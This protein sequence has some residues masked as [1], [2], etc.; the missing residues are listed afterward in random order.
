[1]NAPLRALGLP[2]GPGG[3]SE[4]PTRERAP[5]VLREL[6]LLLGHRV[7]E[8]EL[9][10]ALPHAM[11][12]DTGPAVLAAAARLGL[13]HR[14]WAGTSRRLPASLLPA[15]WI[16]PGGRPALVIGRSEGFLLVAREDGAEPERVH[17][18]AMPGDLYVFAGRDEALEGADRPL[19]PRLLSEHAG[20]IAGL[21]ALS[22][23]SNLTSIALGLVVMI[24]FDMVIPGGQAAP[25]L[26]LGA[27]F[28][29]ALACD[30][31]L[32]TMLARGLG[33]IGERAERQVLGLVFAK[34]LRLPLS[35]VT[36]QDPAAQVMRMRD[37][38]TSREVFTGPL[39]Q[40]ILQVPL[41]IVFLGVIWALAG[42]VVVVPLLILPVQFAAALVL[43]PRAREK[44]HRAALLATER[45]HMILETLSHAG[46]LR[47]IGAEA[48]WLAR[49]R[50]ISAAAAAA[51][52][53]AARAGHAVELVAQLGLP[54]AACGVAAL[55]AHL[56]IEG[57][58]S[59]GALVAAIMLSWRV[60][61]PLQTLFLAISRA[62][63]IV[64]SVAQLHRLQALAEEARPAP[65]APR[66]KGHGRTLRLDGVVLRVPGG[67]T[68]LAGAS[69]ALPE[70][71]R[72]ALT[73][74]SGAGKSTLLRCALGLMPPQAGVVTLGGVNIAQL[75]PSTLRARM[76]YLPQRPA[77]I[78]GTVAQNLRLAAP[79]AEDSDLAEACE[80]VGILEHILAMPQGFA[81]RIN[82]LDKARLAQSLLQGLALAQALL[83][84]P[85]ILLLDDPTHA[86]DRAREERLAALL[87]RL[88]GTVGVL[89]VTHRADLIR[90]CDR[91]FTLDHGQLRVL[92][93]PAGAAL[94]PETAS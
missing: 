57:R 35:A 43:V 84:R 53:R 5:W 56:V 83:R 42:L 32:R 20:P 54:A 26:A 89:I 18:V 3:L 10:E 19:L 7:G 52:A 44:E 87:R 79:A 40:L 94:R 63:Q 24:A 30:V 33:R 11:A 23:L 81:T 25:L 4:G 66:A 28:L 29:G 73:G 50:D 36:S 80:E 65:D 16:A 13:A 67:G 72:V 6:A 76:G 86:L 49:F 47:A 64:D 58:V 62:R 51:H 77:L 60:I 90:S 93:P 82:D 2:A 45:R 92:T 8:R 55:G 12:N 1:M 78:Y 46:T 71:A 59:A 9:L 61:I 41:V 21:A 68:L 34:V 48:A 31:A 22:V 75:D 38:E 88:H 39:P 70:G 17:A 14:R 15:L 74:P 27:G 69:L 85:E 37:L 91:A